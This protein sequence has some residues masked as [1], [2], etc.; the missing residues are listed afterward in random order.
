MT[1]KEINTEERENWE[2][3][4]LSQLC[5]QLYELG[6]VTVSSIKKEVG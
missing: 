4:S 2:N 1:C 3:Y 6:Q 5:H